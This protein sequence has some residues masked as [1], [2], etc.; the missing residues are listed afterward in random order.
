MLHYCRELLI[1]GYSVRHMQ[2]REDIGL[3][4]SWHCT[5]QTNGLWALRR[6]I[7][8]GPVA[9]ENPDYVEAEWPA[10]TDT[11]G[12]WSA[13]ASSSSPTTAAP[14]APPARAVP[15]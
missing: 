10:A 12:P 11:I 3:K 5:P 1:F 15:T 4:N 6:S 9:V 13:S 7:T 2:P 14:S 8:E